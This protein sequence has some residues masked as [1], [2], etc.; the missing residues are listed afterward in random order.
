MEVPLTLPVV[1]LTGASQGIGLAT[2]TL[3]AQKGY[4]VYA[5]CR[6]CK[7]AKELLEL[8]KR[9]PTIIPLELDVTSTASVQRA[10]A[11]I[12][13]R[14]H[15]I[16][17]VINNAGCGVYGPIDSHT[18]GQAQEIF[19][20]NVFGVMRVILAV[21]PIMKKWKGGRIVNIG[22]A[23]GIQPS[24]NLPVYSSSKAALESLSASYAYQLAKWNIQVS[25]IQPGPVN[26][27]F[28]KNTPD[29]ELR[30][31]EKNEAYSDVA[32]E[33]RKYWEKTLDE[34]QSP[35]EIAKIIYKTLTTPHP[36][37]WVPT[38]E[39]VK[40]TIVKHFKDPSGNTRIPEMVDLN[41]KS[42]RT[43]ARAKL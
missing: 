16:D 37:F 6:Y 8:A 5:T 43:A 1:L 12:K 31:K 28:Q 14:E 10:V 26:T 39:A 21:L 11:A 18:M 29:G 22:S 9:I 33:A 38:S 35:L 24:R 34:G 7:N 40:E 15:R 4:K 2:A 13:M 3:L 32:H 36:D 30:I 25:L 27:N 23:S 20:T 41:P 42:R 19:D 17:I